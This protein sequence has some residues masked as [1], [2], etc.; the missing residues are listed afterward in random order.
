MK[1][2][3][4]NN[5]YVPWVRGGAERIAQRSAEGLEKAG[6][7]VFVIATAPIESR[8]DRVF[9]LPSI[10]YNLEKYPLAVRFFWHLWDMVNL[11]NCRKI[12]KVLLEEKP[13]LVITHNLQGI[14][15]LLPGLLRRLKIKHFHT[16]HDIQLLHPSGLMIWGKENILM[17]M[18]AKIY[19]SF[20]RWLIGSPAVVISPS[21]WLLDEHSRRGF[22]S[23]SQTK[24]L[25]NYFPGS[26]FEKLGAGEE[27]SIF[28][29][30]YVGQL[31]KH[32]G[33][34]LLIEAF[35]KLVASGDLKA[36]L[37]IAGPGSQTEEL[38]KIIGETKEIKIVGRK[39]EGEVNDLMRAADCLVVPS[40]CY[41]NS[42][43][44]IY[45]AAAVRLPVIGA[46]IG[47]ITE[48]IETV[49]GML[50][51]PG[52]SAD[53]TD[54]MTKIIKNPEES[55]KIRNK[56]DN[57]AAPDYIDEIIKLAKA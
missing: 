30:L 46:K 35:L 27:K 7:E 42:P 28:T 49:G 11:T 12:R 19:Q 39:N 33:V 51:E 37:L 44:V 21:H 6:H 36:E 16:L 50:F 56:E 45:E 9:Y 32:K 24:V 43:T 3:I 29:F 14:G 54:K 20:M 8:T 13:D 15:Y 55:G 57:L 22:F 52:N 23:Q 40:L 31:E 47:G 17:T 2:V 38:K 25:P 10:F 18:P 26:S 4:I 5:L 1:I 48:L 41:E 34:N 53:L